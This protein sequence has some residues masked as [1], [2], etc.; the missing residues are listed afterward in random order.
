MWWLKVDE[1]HGKTN[2]VKFFNFSETMTIS[3]L[4]V[5]AQRAP[6]STV[7][8]ICFDCQH[9]DASNA[10]SENYLILKTCRDVTKRTPFSRK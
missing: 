5:A 4:K 6:F 1:E 7:L 10:A 9:T 8:S 2:L 3:K